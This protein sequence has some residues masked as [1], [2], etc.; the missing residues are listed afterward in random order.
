MWLIDQIPGCLSG[1]FVT[2][3]AVVNHHHEVKHHGDYVEILFPY[4]LQQILQTMG[5]QFLLF[6]D[7][8]D[9]GTMVSYLCVFNLVMVFMVEFKRYTWGTCG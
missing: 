8:L 9:S 3:C 1:D 4:Q 2:D 5:C 7:L 6:L